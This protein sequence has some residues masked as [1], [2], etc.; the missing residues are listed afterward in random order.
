M[1]IC[2]R[3]EVSD[4]Y[5]NNIGMHKDR[6]MLAFSFS[7]FAD[8]TA[9]ALRDLAQQYVP[10][11]IDTIILDMRNCSGG[12]YIEAQ[13]VARLLNSSQSSNSEQAKIIIL[14]R[15]SSD[16][17]QTN[18]SSILERE[19][20]AE[21]WHS[22]ADGHNATES[23][24]PLYGTVKKAVTLRASSSPAME[25]APVHWNMADF[26]E[27]YPEPIEAARTHP[28]L[29]AHASI[30]PLAWGINGNAWDAVGRIRGT[31]D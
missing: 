19:R 29:L 20:N 10:A 28:M 27:R 31:R 26:R 2:R 25:V 15:G 13:K 21:V 17:L 30:A 16:Q 6:G 7:S 22:V 18:L 5:S 1:R 12:S 8:G 11:S 23:M 3:V 24:D 14:A 9:D 4:G